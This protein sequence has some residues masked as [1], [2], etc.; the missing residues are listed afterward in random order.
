MNTLTTALAA[1]EL[2]I[3]L[4]AL[5]RSWSAWSLHDA[6]N[7]TGGW[8]WIVLGIL[9]LA[10]VTFV[11]VMVVW[12]EFDWNSKRLRQ[13]RGAITLGTLVLGGAGTAYLGVASINAWEASEAADAAHDAARETARQLATA[14]LTERYE[15]QRF[16]P[17]DPSC[18]SSP[19]DKRWPINWLRTALTADPLV[20]DPATATVL[21][22]D[23][24]IVTWTLTI[25]PDTG[26]ARFLPTPDQPTHQQPHA[27]ERTPR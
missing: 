25:D 12:S 21:L 13:L 6:L 10:A 20:D 27:F 5:N 8:N 11:T 1:A 16:T 15:F 9:L 26:D 2:A 4:D 22:N 18:R 24:S 7:G 17:D 3:D 19:C 23:D 14:S